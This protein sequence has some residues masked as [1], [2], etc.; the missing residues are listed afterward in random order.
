MGSGEG[1]FYHY[2]IMMNMT[3]TVHTPDNLP[4]LRVSL[5]YPTAFKGDYHYWFGAAVWSILNLHRGSLGVCGFYAPFP[6]LSRALYRVI[7]RCQCCGIT[8]SVREKKK[9]VIDDIHGRFWAWFVKATSVTAQ[10][11]FIDEFSHYLEGTVEQVRHRQTRGIPSIDDHLIVH[12]LW[13]SFV[14]VH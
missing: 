4:D 9:T 8:V 7:R 14:R 3:V 13:G 10:C 6:R 12:D 1:I 5:A 2:S 11:H